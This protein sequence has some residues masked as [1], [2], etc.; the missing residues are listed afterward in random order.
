V[1]LETG[2]YLTFALS[3]LSALFFL[4]LR[5]RDR[6]LPFGPQARRWALPVIVAIGA[7][8]TVS[9]SLLDLLGYYAPATLFVFGIA[10]PGSLC[11]ERLREDL[12]RRRSAAEA[13]AT[14]WLSW[15]LSRLDDAMADD[16]SRWIE[17]RIDFEWP[18][19]TM[20]LAARHYHNCLYGRLPEEEREGQRIDAA[21]EDIEARLDIARLIDS[22][23]PPGKIRTE[24]TASP[25]GSDP[26][27]QRNLDDLTMLGRRLRHDSAREIDR[28]LAV[29]YGNGL[30]R[31]E[32]YRPPVLLLRW[33]VDG[34]QDQLGAGA[35]GGQH[36]GQGPQ[37][38]VLVAG[39][40]LADPAGRDAHLLGQVGAGD[41][42]LAHEPAHLVDE[43][44]G[45]I[46]IPLRCR[47][48]DGPFRGSFRH[49]ASLPAV[50]CRLP[51]PR[52]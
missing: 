38:Q 24:I 28:L 3:C 25:L 4:R 50:S 44:A 1:S 29:A 46:G 14:L 48:P 21:L 19:H 5:C 16:K 10:A 40:D 20:L 9:A 11:I 52:C 36:A 7:A 26:R 31:L 8:S 13:A 45:E 30:Y 15:L 34:V 2:L 39:Q 27:Y 6:G 37:R 18:D 51:S 23:L 43:Q 32:R 49:G 47:S 42:V 35:H 22:D 41:L 33:S 12:P 17:T